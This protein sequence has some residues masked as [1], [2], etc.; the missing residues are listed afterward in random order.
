MG[1]VL[2]VEDDTSVANV[3]RNVLGRKHEL[4]HFADAPSALEGI[5]EDR[6]DVAL[7]NMCLPEI[8]GDQVA[9]R[10]RKINPSAVRIL[11]SALILA[12]TDPRMQL[13]ELVL[14]KPFRDL[15]EVRRMVAEAVVVARARRAR[16]A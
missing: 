9:E 8:A 7:I 5:G 2:V 3:F 4:T 16:F 1:Q 14:P 12:D 11:A 13:F 15:E 10:L 6:Y